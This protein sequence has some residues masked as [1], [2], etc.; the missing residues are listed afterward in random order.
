MGLR[1]AKITFKSEML[2]G[3]SSVGDIG[4]DSGPFVEDQ[5]L[6]NAVTS[7]LFSRN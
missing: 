6:L 2:G 5:A 4:G 3:I 7:Y 1:A